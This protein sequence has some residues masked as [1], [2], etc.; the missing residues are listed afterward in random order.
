MSINSNLLGKAM[1]LAK[2]S[3]MIQ[4]HGAVLFYQNQIY[5]NGINSGSRSRLMGRD[6]PS[7]HAEM[8]CI[9]RVF[10]PKYRLLRK[11]QQEV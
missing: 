11:K 3:R 10:K 1:E 8:D 7:I 9:S 6:F 4:K 2:Q 5:G